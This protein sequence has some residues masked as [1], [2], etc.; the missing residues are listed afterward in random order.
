[1]RRGRSDRGALYERGLAVVM[2]GRRPAAEEVT[3]DAPPGRLTVRGLHAAYGRIEVLHGIDLE[4]SPGEVLALLGPNGAGKS[5]L[6]KGC[7][8]RL[9]PRSGR[10]LVSGADVTGKGPA[11]LAHLGLCSI[12]EGRGVFPNLSVRENLLMWTYGGASRSEVEERAF[13]RFPRL[14]E[15]RNQRAGTLSGGEQQMVAFA[16]ALAARP[17]VL[18]LDEISMGLAPLV[19]SELYAVVGDIAAGGTTVVLAE[20]FVD[21]ALE[22][23]TRA[24]ILSQGRLEQTGTPQEMAGAA[25][26]S[27]LG[28]SG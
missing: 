20:Q 2:P 11:A 28:K 18:L 6:L 21:S 19:V 26:A 4:V 9:R 16:R 27:Y 13:E 23:A 24:A 14:A 17:A 3:P 22:V 5:T 8:G 10:V 25:A 1:M 7:G 12:P 15:R